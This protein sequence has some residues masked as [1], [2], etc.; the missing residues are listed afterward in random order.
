MESTIF[1]N[2]TKLRKVSIVLSVITVSLF[3][4][5]T[6][7]MDAGPPP[8][9]SKVTDD[10][11]YDSPIMPL[12]LTLLFVAPA[13]VAGIFASFFKKIKHQII[14]WCAIT[15]GI[16]FGIIVL[17]LLMLVDPTSFELPEGYW[18]VENEI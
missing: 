6:L 7:P 15:I 10:P 3:F 8:E 11:H 14:V 1:R 17:G 2:I 12:L 18:N 9:G 16:W 5:I 13:A 4:A